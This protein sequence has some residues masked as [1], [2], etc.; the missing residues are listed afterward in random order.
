VFKGLLAGKSP[1]ASGLQFFAIAVG[2][3]LAGYLIGIAVQRLF[4]GITLPVG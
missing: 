1:I 4:P 3:A 2:A